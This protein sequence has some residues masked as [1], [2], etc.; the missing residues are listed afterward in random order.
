MVM[1]NQKTIDETAR[2]PERVI[3]AIP[4]Q[5]RSGHVELRHGRKRKLLFFF[6]TS[7]RCRNCICNGPG[8]VRELDVVEQSRI[9]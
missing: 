8:I 9:G 5:V 7:I 6:M 1:S 3:A 2:N 4:I